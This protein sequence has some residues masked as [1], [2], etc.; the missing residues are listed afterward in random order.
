MIKTLRA[1][2][3][4]A[5]NSFRE[6]VRSKV[7]AV[8]LF[9][10]VLLS[11]SAAVL[12]QMSLHEERRVTVDVAI[13]M[14]T[15]F[16]VVIAIYTTVTSLQTELERRT[17]YTLLS[18][19]IARWHFLVGK[20]L[21]VALLMLAVVTGMFGVTAAL[22]LVQSFDV[23]AELVAAFGTIFL[24]S[25][26]VTALALMFSSFSTPLLTGM[27]TAS[28]FVVGN[29][30]SLLDEVIPLLRPTLG[31]AAETIVGVLWIIVPNF[32]QLNLADAVV[33]FVPVSS[34]YILAAIGYALTEVT[35]LLTLA[36]VIFRRRDFA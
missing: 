13:F 1:I 32:E 34:Q 20:Y 24:Q 26:I 31:E 4:I 2:R 25:A 17:I 21:G 12:G 8:L 6:A 30:L 23:T 9:F 19:P 3:A 14:S 10:A 33:H 27:M 16:S 18:K 15:M 22:L 35:V 7:L 36:A 11:I 28:V 5:L 29:L